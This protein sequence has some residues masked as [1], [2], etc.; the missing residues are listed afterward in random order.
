[1]QDT[2]QIEVFEEVEKS[3]PSFQREEEDLELLFKHIKYYFPNYN[4][5][6][7]YLQM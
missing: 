1:L 7:Q 5:L 3:F 2:L 6:I 4:Y